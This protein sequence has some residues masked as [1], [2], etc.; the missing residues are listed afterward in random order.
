VERIIETT[1]NYTHRYQDSPRLQ[2]SVERRE[3]VT[4]KDSHG[5]RLDES[6]VPQ[7]N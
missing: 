7:E 2:V 5:E 4:Y 1:L 3:S 6:S